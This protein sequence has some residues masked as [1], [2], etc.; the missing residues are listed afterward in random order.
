[1]FRRR[2]SFTLIAM[3]VAY[4][5]QPANHVSPVTT[6]LIVDGVGGLGIAALLVLALV[7]RGVHRRREKLAHRAAL[8]QGEPLHVG[9]SVL[10]G[11][12]A[13]EGEGD[14]VVVAI[15]QHGREFLFKN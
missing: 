3:P 8:R 7:R 2:G 5:A 15:E 10:A 14:A 13:D 11:V 1:M 6:A 12:V 4:S 9:P